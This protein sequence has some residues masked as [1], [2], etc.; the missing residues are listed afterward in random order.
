MRTLAR[1]LALSLER[2]AAMMQQQQAAHFPHFLLTHSSTPVQPFLSFFWDGMG[3][4]DDVFV[5]AILLRIHRRQNDA[6]KKWV[7]QRSN[8]SNKRETTYQL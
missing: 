5:V 7:H 8:S 6:K 4:A 2:R 3:K 1:S